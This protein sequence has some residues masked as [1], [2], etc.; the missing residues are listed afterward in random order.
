MS[1]KEPVAVDEIL[2]LDGSAELQKRLVEAFLGITDD[3][4]N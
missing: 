4:T 3:S 1:E 2:T